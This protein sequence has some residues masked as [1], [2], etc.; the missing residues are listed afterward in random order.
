MVSMNRVIVAGNLAKDPE[1]KETSNGKTLGIFP[2]AVSRQWKSNS[3]EAKKQV[4]FFRIVVWNKSAENCAKFL[5][6]GKAVLVEGR[7]QNRSFATA[8]GEMRYTTEIIGD[9]VTFLNNH[10][11]SKDKPNSEK[12]ASAAA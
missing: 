7:L 2:L 1:L 4:Y 6:K 12:P 10:S 5:T 9:N 8:N 11:S 3:G